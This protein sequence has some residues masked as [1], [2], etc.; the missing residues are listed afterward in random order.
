MSTSTSSD[1]IV[2][3]N[4][5][6]TLDCDYDGVPR[7]SITWTFNDTNVSSGSSSVT[8]TETQSSTGGTSRL[9]ATNVFP[10]LAQGKYYCIASNDIGSANTTFMVRKGSEWIPEELILIFLLQCNT[11]VKDV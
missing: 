5:Q 8:I 2:D 1:R 4:G 3:S 11:S 7:P 10:L 9:A 6:F